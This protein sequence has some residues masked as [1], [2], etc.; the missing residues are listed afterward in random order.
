MGPVLFKGCKEACLSNNLL[1]PGQCEGAQ[2]DHLWGGQWG[3][4]HP[5][6]NTAQTHGF[7]GVAWGGALQGKVVFPELSGPWRRFPPRPSLDVQCW[8]AGGGPRDWTGNKRA[9]RVSWGSW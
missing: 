5:F 6:E 4:V 3:E 7:G 9:A 2:A 8:R 1:L